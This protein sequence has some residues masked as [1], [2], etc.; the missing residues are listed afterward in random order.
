[1]NWNWTN[2]LLLLAV[3]AGHCEWLAAVLNRVHGRALPQKVLDRVSLAH[4]AAVLG[5]AP[6]LLFGFAFGGYELVGDGS[7]GDVPGAWRAYFVACGCGAVSLIV[8]T[9]RHHLRRVPDGATVSSE[10][11]DVAVDLGF[12]P[13][14]ER[15]RW[16]SSL[17]GNRQFR[18]EVV[19]LAVCLPRLPAAWDGVTVA[20]LSDTHFHGPV[21]REFFKHAFAIAADWNADLALFG[22]DLLDDPALVDWIPSTFGRLNCPLGCHFILGNHDARHADGPTRDALAAVGWRDLGGRVTVLDADRHPLA[23]G[24][25]ETPWFGTP[26]DW[27]AAPPDTPRLLVSHTPD[28]APRA[29]KHR[30]D[31]MLAGHT[32]GGQV[33]L[34][35]FGPIYAPSR[36]GLRFAGGTHRV[37]DT[38]LHVSRGLSGKTPVRYGATPEVTRVTLRNGAAGG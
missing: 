19:D 28:H 18:L 10:T 34:P 7:W 11:R 17:P 31:L 2:A 1:M 25:D 33:W 12:K 23:L 9:L 24:G 13:A 16:L 4:H 15:R 32:H 5:F 3:Y 37:G 36:H 20:F 38:L 22:G 35:P 26:P 21:R 8:G 14:G 30:V 29:A 6:V 27:S